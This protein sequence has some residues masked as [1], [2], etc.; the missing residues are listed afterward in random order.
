MTKSKKRQ[1]SPSVSRTS[2]TLSSVGASPPATPLSAEVLAGRPLVGTLAETIFRSGW[3]VA[4]EI[5]DMV[6]KV[7]KVNNSVDVR[8]RFEEYWE[9]VKSKAKE[10]R[11]GLRL[12]RLWADGKSL[13]NVLSMA[14]LRLQG[15]LSFCVK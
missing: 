9:M 6:E 14:C 2:S 11:V 10:N 8:H 3:A 4:G 13:L 12:E 5:G 7:L 15:M 1:D